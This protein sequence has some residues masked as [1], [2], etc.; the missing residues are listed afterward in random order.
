MVYVCMRV[1]VS[2]ILDGITSQKQISTVRTVQFQ[3]NQNKL[4]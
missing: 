3:L 1:H 2:E 4:K